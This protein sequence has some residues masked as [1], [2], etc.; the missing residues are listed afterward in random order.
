MARHYRWAKRYAENPSPG[1]SGFFH[2]GIL[3]PWRR[4]PD[5]GRPSAQVFQKFDIVFPCSPLLPAS[6]WPQLSLHLGARLLCQQ[7]YDMR[8]AAR[9]EN[10]RTGVKR[11][12]T[13]RWLERP[14]AGGRDQQ[15]C[16]ACWIGAVPAARPL[17]A[18]YAADKVV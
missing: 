11:R 17:W 1:K 6:L 7:I 5:I 9:V 15:P 16:K 3:P 4:A 12:R 18:C 14:V 2:I 13:V 8:G 10:I